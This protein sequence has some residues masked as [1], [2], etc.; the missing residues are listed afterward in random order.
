M[1]TSGNCFGT[2]ALSISVNSEKYRKRMCPGLLK[3]K[4]KKISY[5]EVKKGVNK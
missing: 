5:F 4:S 2:D 3:T 1:K